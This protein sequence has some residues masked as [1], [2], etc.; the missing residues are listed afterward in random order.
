MDPSIAAPTFL[1]HCSHDVS[2]STVGAFIDGIAF[3]MIGGSKDAPSSQLEE[4][5]L[6]QETGEL[7]PPVR[8]EASGNPEVGENSF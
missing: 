6:P 4:E 1:L 5:L 3:G 2:N 8:Q 7:S